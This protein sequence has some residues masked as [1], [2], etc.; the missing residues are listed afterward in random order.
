MSEEKRYTD[1][2]KV[3][4]AILISVNRN[5]ISLRNLEKIYQGQEGRRIPL[6]GHGNTVGLLNSMTDTI[7]TVSKTKKKKLRLFFLK[8]I[9]ILLVK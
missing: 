3:L 6:F 1:L 5:G 9:K 8:L 4:R 7:Y 2:K